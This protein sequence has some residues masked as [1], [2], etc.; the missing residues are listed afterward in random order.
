MRTRNRFYPPPVAQYLPSLR[1][2]AVEFYN[3][4]LVHGGTHVAFYVSS[5]ATPVEGLIENGQ[6]RVTMDRRSWD[7]MVGAMAGKV[8]A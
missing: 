7:S 5:D 2:G 4:E 1:I 6:A 8:A 3:V